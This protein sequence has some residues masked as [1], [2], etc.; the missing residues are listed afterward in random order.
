MQTPAFHR[1][2]SFVLAAE[3]GLSM[4]ENDRGNWT[5]G[6]IGKGSLKGTKYGIS[7]AAYPA[8]DIAG[9]R[10]DDA[11]RIYLNDYWLPAKCGELPP[12]LALVHM[13]FA[14]NAGVERA[15]KCLQVALGVKVDGVIGPQTISA[16]RVMDQ[17]E[18]CVNYLAERALFYARS[19]LAKEY[20]RGW[21]RRVMRA[22]MEVG[23]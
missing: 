7:A 9:L 6:E 17:T 14:V 1:A 23:R 16:S 21:M 10:L 12:R 5:G 20:G 3:G 13:D 22:A 15:A 2:M 11:K 4:D 8:L 18:A 19:P